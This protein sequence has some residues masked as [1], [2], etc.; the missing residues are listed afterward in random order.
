[1]NKNIIFY[2]S[3]TGN[4][5]KASKDIGAALENCEI[6]LMNKPFKFTD[7]YERIGFVFPTYAMGLPNI[8]KQ[9][10]EGTDFSRNQKA[11]YFC[12]AT[13]GGRSGN[14]LSSVNNLL[15]SKGMELS[16]GNEVA[17]FANYVA[18]YAMAND[19]QQKA[20]K[21]NERTNIIAGE[22]AQKEVKQKFPSNMVL[23]LV[24]KAVGGS[25]RGKAQ[26]F[27]VSES[28][29]GCKKCEAVCPVVNITMKDGKPSFANKCEQCMAC[30]QWCPKQAINYKNKTQNRG[31]Y[32][33]PEIR[34]EDMT[35]NTK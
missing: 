12:V 17:M 28:C 34:F 6:V 5:L 24:H 25:L 20:I 2:F 33:H 13:C 32:H 1:M 23:N 14:S 21:S 3:G 15:K 30:I 11:Y 31:R 19:A 16:Y 8:V 4:S 26:K 18:L 9:F 27:N 22:I 10:I 7:S 29:I 35:Q